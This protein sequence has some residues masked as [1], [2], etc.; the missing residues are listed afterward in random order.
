VRVLVVTV[1][2]DP[3]DARIRHRQIEALRAAGHEVI[4]AAPFRAYSR[5]QPIAFES[6]DLP[7]AQ[8]RRRVAAARAA[9]KLLRER[10]R[11]A[12]IVLLHDP[13]LLV[14]ATGVKLPGLVW[15]VHEDTAAAMEMKAW[16]P[17]PVRPAAKSLVHTLE[18]SAE[19]R[20]R[21]VLAEDSYVGRFRRSH[22]V[23]P[24]SVLSPADT[25]PPPGD[26]R[27]VYLGRLTIARGALDMIDVG[28]RL[29]PYVKVELI[30]NA[31]DD[32]R[33]A[34]EEAHHAGQVQW[35]GFVPND[36]ALPMLRGAL[37]GLSLL[38][39]QPNYA[40]SR[41]TKIM[42]YMAH[43]VPVVTTPN[44]SS[45]DLVQRHNCGLVVPYRD[46]HAVLA[47]VMRLRGDLDLRRRLAANG[48][49]AACRLYTW[50][51]DAMTFV[52]LLE[53]W[54]QSSF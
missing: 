30:G 25:L 5:D 43:G 39:D 2:H 21:L 37:A 40:L 10:G 48:R 8:G 12:D 49:D 4:F 41:P 50:D 31:D 33:F 26:D 19:R 11:G 44:P 20:A 14:A 16:I 38:H 45:A 9:R 22:P 13:E 47:A 42:E 15:D 18:R 36:E 17:R 34:I 32:C 54:A 46:P 3:E 52:D 7:R 1:V 23:V 29:S 53:Q 6:I 27:V 28:R 51:R 35:R 24:N